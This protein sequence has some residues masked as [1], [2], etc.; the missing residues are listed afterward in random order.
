MALM[1]ARKKSELMILLSNNVN[2]IAVN[3]TKQGLF[4]LVT[5]ES[6]N[7]EIFQQEPKGK[8]SNP[9]LKPL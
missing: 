3:N 9:K 4:P 6:S 8:K 5:G 1:P 7:G 2:N